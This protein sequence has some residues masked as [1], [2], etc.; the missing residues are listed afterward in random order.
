MPQQHQRGGV[1]H[2]AGEVGEHRDVLPVGGTPDGLVNG[3]PGHLIHLAVRDDRLLEGG[4]ARG[5][6]ADLLRVAV[7][8]IADR[9]ELAP[10]RDD[11][12][13]LLADLPDGCDGKLL[14]WLLLSLG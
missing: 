10:E 9:G 14:P 7:D 13:R 4:D 3:Q 11:R 2:P 8:P 12:A 1:G 5:P 6:V